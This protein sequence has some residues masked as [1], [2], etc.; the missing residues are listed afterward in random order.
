MELTDGEL[1]RVRGEMGSIGNLMHASMV[2]ERLEPL[3]RY[4]GLTRAELKKIVLKE[5]RTL[6]RNHDSLV[7]KLALYKKLLALTDEG[8]KEAVLAQPSILGYG[9][10][11]A[12]WELV[13]S[14]FLPKEPGEPGGK[15]VGAT[16]RDT[17]GVSLKRLE[18]RVG[19]LEAFQG[20]GPLAREWVSRIARRTDADWRA[21]VPAAPADPESPRE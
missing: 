1:A 8:L 6:S 17:F 13:S 21:L 14:R 7:T 11:E 9:D 2:D 15:S 10:I 3:Q 4:L 5:P 12:K 18:T 16:L 20:E 19:E